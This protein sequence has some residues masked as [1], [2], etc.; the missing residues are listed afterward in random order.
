MGAGASRNERAGAPPADASLLCAC[1]EALRETTGAETYPAETLIKERFLTPVL[2]EAGFPAALDTARALSPDELIAVAVA[3]A[4][5]RAA[6]TVA[7]PVAPQ[8]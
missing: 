2:A 6:P 7:S 3:A 1:A 5:E 8:A 4:A